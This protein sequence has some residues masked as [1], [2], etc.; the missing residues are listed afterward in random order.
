[1]CGIIFAFNKNGEQVNEWVR[2]Q[3]QEQLDRGKQGFGVSMAE[4]KNSKIET[5]RS[6]EITE[7][8]MALWLKKSC[9]TLL[10]HRMPTSSKNTVRQTHPILVG[11]SEVGM[12]YKYLI[13]HNGVISNTQ[14]LKED[15]EILGFNYTT[16]VKKEPTYKNEIVKEE[17]NDSESLAIELAM[18]IEN[19]S[20]KRI[21]TIGSVAAVAIK[22]DEKEETPISVI[23]YRNE[24]NPLKLNRENKMMT[25]SSEGPGNQVEK[26]MLFEMNLNTG[27]VKKRKLESEAY[28]KLT[29]SL[30]KPLSKPKNRYS[31]KTHDDKEYDDEMYTYYQGHTRQVQLLTPEE[32]AKDMIEEL[33]DEY[34]MT[35]EYSHRGF[36][37]ELDTE[38]LIEAIRLEIDTLNIKLGLSKSNKK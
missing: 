35:A 11:G 38:K 30:N 12:K 3:L 10:H 24:G 33:I 13:V 1:M 36:D 28:R 19:N 6:V 27:T 18:A 9:L 16:L 32:E 20:I 2:R 26:E 25:L 5:T 22:I 4:T 17:Y 31:Y 23:W 29:T 37:V 14:K 15:H 21:S 34:M 7:T 8:L